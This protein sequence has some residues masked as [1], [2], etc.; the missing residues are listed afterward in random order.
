MAD[1]NEK[2][3]EITNTRDTTAEFT[4]EDINGNKGMAFLA[5]LWWLVLI[6]LFCAKDSKYVRFH[7]NQG[8]VLTIV[9]TVGAI[10]FRVLGKLMLVGWLFR[11][12]GGVFD[13]GVFIL[14]IIGIIN[15]INGKA[16]ELPI[17]GHI[18]LIK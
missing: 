18:S 7:V 17:I 8:L 1:I 3:E 12:V 6:P 10:V 14:F 15:V 2:I 11:I 4:P 16:K 5:Y 9:D 13:L